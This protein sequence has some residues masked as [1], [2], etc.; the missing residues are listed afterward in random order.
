MREKFARGIPP[1][2]FK[3]RPP[4]STWQRALTNCCAGSAK[5]LGGC[6][7]F[8]QAFCRSAGPS[9]SVRGSDTA[10]T[11]ENRVSETGNLNQ[12]MVEKRLGTIL[13]HSM[14]R[15]VI[16]GVRVWA[17]KFASCCIGAMS[18]ARGCSSIGLKEAGCQNQDCQILQRFSALRLSCR[19]LLRFSQNRR[20]V[21]LPLPRCSVLQVVCTRV[22]SRRAPVQQRHAG[23][24]HHDVGTSWACGWQEKFPYVVAQM[25][26]KVL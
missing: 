15:A 4:E 11:G 22:L 24:I 26:Q 14:H 7:I 8:A 5:V 17:C 19:V 6:I 12:K 3:T 13:R 2:P 16:A 10:V 9:L 18:H 21:S 25:I 20:A 23:C 1:Q